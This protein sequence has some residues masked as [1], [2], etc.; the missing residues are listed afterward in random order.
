MKEDIGAGLLG[1]CM[2]NG[3]EKMGLDIRRPDR[4]IRLK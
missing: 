3:W 2:C 4:I 1:R